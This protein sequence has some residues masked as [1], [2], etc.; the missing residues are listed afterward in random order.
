MKNLMR[1]ILG[2]SVACGF[3]AMA[4]PSFAL[5]SGQVMAGKRTGT[6][7]S[8]T[9][10]AESTKLDGTEIGA[11]VHIDPIP[12]VPVSFGLDLRSTSYDAKKNTD[13][14]SLSS[15]TADLEV[16][17]WLP[18]V[19]VLTPFARLGYTIFG[20]TKVA[21]KTT[22]APEI[23]IDAAYKLSG[24]TI[25]LGAKFSV[26]PLIGVFVEY[27]MSTQESK[28]DKSTVTGLE[29]FPDAEAS[30]QTELKETQ[31][32]STNVILVGLSVGI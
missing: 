27:D 24:Y 22:T 32:V 12:L 28:F 21:T 13:M 6:S 20:A 26:L 15:L 10:G 18:M 1:G 9:A 30:L 25:G 5:I 14:D 16:M 2:A 23:N 4:T 11:A 7:K 8:S 17:A 29:A 19:P 31:T 3:V